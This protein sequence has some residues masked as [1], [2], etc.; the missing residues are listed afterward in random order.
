MKTK[1]KIGDL[2]M[3]KNDE[4]IGMIY[5]VYVSDA[6]DN[7]YYVHWYDGLENWCKGSMLEQL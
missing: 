4:R 1:F 6:P 2:T 3:R 5:K 7:S